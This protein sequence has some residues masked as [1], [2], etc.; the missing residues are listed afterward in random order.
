MGNSTMDKVR[1]GELGYVG[2][3]VPLDDR[4]SLR[5][6]IASAHESPSV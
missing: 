3:E 5:E 2:I 1:R 6:A 4:L